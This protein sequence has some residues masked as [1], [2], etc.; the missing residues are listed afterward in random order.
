MDGEG[1]GFT[2]DDSINLFYISTMIE[3]GMG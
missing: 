3:N 2:K 1:R